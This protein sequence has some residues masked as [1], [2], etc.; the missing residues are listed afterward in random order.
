[1]SAGFEIVISKDLIIAI[2]RNNAIDP[3]LRSE[4]IIGQ[5]QG[6]IN[7]SLS[8]CVSIAF[9]AKLVIAFTAI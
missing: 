6:S 8:W 2:D 4:T 5:L 9:V 1:M 3:T 7:T